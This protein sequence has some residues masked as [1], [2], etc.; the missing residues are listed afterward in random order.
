MPCYVFYIAARLTKF[1]SL[2][3]VINMLLIFLL[4][5]KSVIHLPHSCLIV[6]YFISMTVNYQHAIF[7]GMIGDNSLN[8]PG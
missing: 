7:E 4:S 3:D 2:V 8:F 6:D 1:V 5:G